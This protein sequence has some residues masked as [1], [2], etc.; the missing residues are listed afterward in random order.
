MKKTISILLSLVIGICL[1]PAGVF[2]ATPRADGISE[3]TMRY[4]GSEANV[5]N[6]GAAAVQYALNKEEPANGQ[7]GGKAQRKAFDWILNSTE[8]RVMYVD[9]LRITEKN[10]VPEGAQARYFTVTIAETENGTVTVSSVTPSQLANVIIRPEPAQG[11]RVDTVTVTDRDGNTIPVTANASGTY[12]YR[13]PPKDVT[14]TV[15][16]VRADVTKTPFEDVAAGAYYEDAVVWALNKEITTG[17]SD[18]TFTPNGTVRR[19]EAVTFL[20]RAAGTPEPKDT[21]NPFI[22]VSNGE[23]YYKAVLWAVENGITKGTTDATFSPESTLQRDQLLTF[24]SRA[25][26]NT[27]ANGNDWSEAAVAWANDNKLTEGA[28]GS[29][30]AKDGCPRRDVVYYLWRYYTQR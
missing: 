16:F 14:V 25:S 4:T 11:F 30:A 5:I 29:F 18:T 8:E 20:W 7:G 19:G 15:T 9:R 27:V 23:Y 21:I 28:E 3:I 12:S 1:L 24:L 22:D 2:A 17:T 6:N 10:A 13:Q 26:G